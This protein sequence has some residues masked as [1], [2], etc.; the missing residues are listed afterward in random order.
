MREK[1]GEKRVIRGK[2]RDRKVNNTRPKT[3]KE[4]ERETP[5][6]PLSGLA[7]PHGCLRCAL[8]LR[9]PSVVLRHF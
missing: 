9:K 5:W 6:A 3:D 4:S 2:Q 1:N 8:E 7:G